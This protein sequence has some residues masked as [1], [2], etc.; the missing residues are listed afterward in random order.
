MVVISKSVKHSRK[1][2]HR[3][4][5]PVE[6]IGVSNRPKSFPKKNPE[7]SMDWKQRENNPK[8]SMMRSRV[9]YPIKNPMQNPIKD[10]IKIRLK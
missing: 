5:Y 7:R 6:F 3:D 10:P 8:F 2:L 1:Y 9:R 4:I